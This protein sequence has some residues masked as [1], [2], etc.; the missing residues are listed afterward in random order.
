LLWIS[1][2][3]AV[4]LIASIYFS[5]RRLHG[6]SADQL[7]GQDGQGGA[8][9]VVVDA[10]KESPTPLVENPTPEPKPKTCSTQREYLEIHH[11]LGLLVNKNHE[12]REK[13]KA[14]FLGLVNNFRSKFGLPF[15]LA[16]TSG[17]AEEQ[18]VVYNNCKSA[19]K[20]TVNIVFVARV[21]GN[22]Q[23]E[24]L[25]KSGSLEKLP[26]HD[27]G[28]D[29]ATVNEIS[30]KGIPFR[31][32]RA[33]AFSEFYVE[34][35]NLYSPMDIEGLW[36]RIDSKSNW[37]VVSNPPGLAKL[38]SVEPAAK[39]AGCHPDEHCFEAVSGKSKRH[40]VAPIYCESVVKAAGDEPADERTDEKPEAKDSPGGLQ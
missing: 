40:F 25:T 5:S 18:N 11:E 35:T 8:A 28:I 10:P 20:G 22:K 30:G 29:I 26:L 17:R 24:V 3:V 21:V 38:Q 14:R 27:S 36:L 34:G 12:I 15:P 13:Q 23:I 32:W 31:T 4:I 19:C 2:G 39:I 16:V 1:V 7:P 6:R 37:Q 33:P 9:T